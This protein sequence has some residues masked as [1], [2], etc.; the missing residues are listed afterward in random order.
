MIPVEEAQA[1]VLEAAR[2]TGI[3][4]LMLADAHGRTLPQPI[5][6]RSTPP[7]ADKSARDG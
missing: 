4:L 7:P 3:E 6:A 1:R 5:I 2:S